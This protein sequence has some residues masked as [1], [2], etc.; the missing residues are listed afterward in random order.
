MISPVKFE[1]NSRSPT[2]VQVVQAGV[3][4]GQHGL[5]AAARIDAQHLTAGH[6][7]GDD[8][9][10]GVEL[11]RVGHAEIAR[12]PLRL[13]ALSGSIAPDLVGR[14]QR[15]V[16]QPVGPDLHGV[17]RRQVLQQDPRRAAAEVEFHQPSALAAFVDEQPTLVDGDAVRAGEVVAQHAGSAVGLARAD[18][19]VHHLGG[20][21]VAVGVEGDVVGRDDVAA[22]G[23]DGLQPAGADVQRADLA[24][25]HLRDV[26]PAVGTGAQ[27]VG[28]EQPAGRGEPLEP[29]ALGDVRVRRRVPGVGCS[30]V[31][32]GL[33]RYQ[34]RLVQTIASVTVTIRP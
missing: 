3:Q 17:G 34:A 14:H 5:L 10:L 30:D 28:A 9:A 11:H 21:Q 26:D 33:G 6:L 22:L 24:A 27:P 19:A 16:Q 25:G 8:V 2:K 4:L 29:P 7:G 32:I 12:D 1:T 31:L 23:A 15:E 20:V 18:P 13:T